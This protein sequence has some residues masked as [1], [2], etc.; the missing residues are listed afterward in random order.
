M[1]T[2]DTDPSVPYIL[3]NPHS[4]V[5]GMEED[6]LPAVNRLAAGQKLIVP[7]LAE[8]LACPCHL[9]QVEGEGHV[10]LHPLGT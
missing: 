1:Y 8:A 2:P 3:F 9:S 6:D 4:W 7:L 5:G 10:T